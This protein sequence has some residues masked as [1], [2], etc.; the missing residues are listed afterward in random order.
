M[1]MSLASIVQLLILLLCSE[2][3]TGQNSLLQQLL[4]TLRSGVPTA[5]SAPLTIDQEILNAAGE[6]AFNSDI[7]DVTHGE[8]QFQGDIIFKYGDLAG[9]LEPEQSA[10]DGPVRKKRKTAQDTTKRWT[11][12]TVLIAF[13]S[14]SAF[15]PTQRREFQNAIDQWQQKTCLRFRTPTINDIHQG[16]SFVFVQNGKGCSSPLGMN[17]M[18]QTGIFR[19]QPLTLA[20]QCRTRRIM[21]HEIGHCL[22]LIH[23][24]SRSDRDSHISV[25]WKNVPMHMRHNFQ[26][27][28]TQVTNNR[29]TPYDYESLMHYGPK[30][31]STN[32]E[33]TLRTTNPSYQDRIGAFQEISQYD[34]LAINNMYDC[35]VSMQ[36]TMVPWWHF[37]GKRKK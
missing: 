18:R 3:I 37:V 5:Q 13:D 6:E 2:Q 27:F 22:G 12:N 36:Q 30:A 21:M 17:P 26:R 25:L 24:Q 32:G 16:K 34:A 31:F 19:Y 33:P 15:T 1:D 7:S 29:N 23:E 28:T 8:Y 14:N 11:E 9:A 35:G 10:F 4:Q 20:Q